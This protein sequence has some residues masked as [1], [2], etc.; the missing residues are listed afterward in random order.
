MPAVSSHCDS[1][2]GCA[3]H[4]PNAHPAA[5][6]TG[7]RGVVLLMKDTPGRLRRTLKPAAASTWQRALTTTLRL[8]PPTPPYVLALPWQRLALALYTARYL[9]PNPL[10]PDDD[11]ELYGVAFG[12]LRCK[13]CLGVSSWLVS[14][15][16]LCVVSRFASA[17]VFGRSTVSPVWPGAVSCLLSRR[18]GVTSAAM[19]VNHDSN[20]SR[21]E[22][23]AAM[24]RRADRRRLPLALQPVRRL[25]H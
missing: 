20:L 12:L 16:S 15:F 1:G 19:E 2:R 7:A 23:Q 10:L 25:S 24:R 3:H 13:S 6:T 4:H 17:C 14:S 5:L 22:Y 9:Q 18:C 11:T 21:L 8:P